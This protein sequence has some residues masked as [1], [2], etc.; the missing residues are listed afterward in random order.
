MINAYSERGAMVAAITT[1]LRE[2]GPLTVP[3]IAAYLG[4]KPQA[5]W[6]AIRNMSTAG[7][8]IPKRIYVSEWRK[9]GGERSSRLWPV[10]SLGALADKPRPGTLAG[11]VLRLRVNSVFALGDLYAGTST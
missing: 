2:H 6:T 11:G 9:T 7:I 4:V 3:A 10:Y 1:V 8:N 5:I